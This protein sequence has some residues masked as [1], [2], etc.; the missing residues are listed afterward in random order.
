LNGAA[1][2]HRHLWRRIAARHSSIC[3]DRPPTSLKRRAF[4]L[5]VGSEERMKSKLVNNDRQRTYVVVLDTGEEA[6]SSLTRFAKEQRLSAAQ[7]TAIGAIQD[8]VLGYFDWAKKEYRRIPVTEQVEVVSLIGDV[9]LDPKGE[10]TLHA[11]AVLGRVDGTTLG[12]HLLEAR[13]RPTLEVVINE[14]PAHLRKRK[15]AETGLAL[16]DLDGRP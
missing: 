4:G 12:G 10:P 16:I 14:S 6:V 5:G 7:I 9:A 1:P 13:V 2:A 15:D 11:H 3:A 8:A